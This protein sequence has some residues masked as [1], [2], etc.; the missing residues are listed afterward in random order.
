MNKKLSIIGAFIAGAAVVALIGFTT[1]NAVFPVQQVGGGTG[2]NATSSAGQILISTGSSTYTPA[3]LQCSGGCSATNSS[4]SVIVMAGIGNGN[5]FITPTSS[6]ATDSLMYFP[7]AGSSTVA[8]IPPVTMWAPQCQVTNT[9][10]GPGATS[11]L[12]YWGPIYI[13]API[14]AS[15]VTLDI[16]TADASTTDRSDF[17]LYT[18][19]GTATATGTLVFNTGPI[20]LNSTGIHNFALLQTVFIA[21]GSYMIGIAAATTTLR[22]ESCPAQFG[23]AQGQAGSNTSSSNSGGLHLQLPTSTVYSSLSNLNTTVIPA[24]GLY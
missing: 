5:L 24:F 2:T 9:T 11:T 16:G 17:G 10:A 7:T 14:N 22:F 13:S 20:Q 15:S 1:A 23:L 4:G 21:P 3:F 12:N 18:A 8:S 19:P 6:I